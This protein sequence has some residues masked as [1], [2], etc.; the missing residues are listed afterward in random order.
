MLADRATGNLRPK[1]SVFRLY[2]GSVSEQGSDSHICG[3]RGCLGQGTLQLRAG[4]QHPPVFGIGCIISHLAGRAAKSFLPATRLHQDFGPGDEAGIFCRRSKS[5]YG[6]TV[7]IQ[8]RSREACFLAYTGPCRCQATGQ[9]MPRSGRW[10]NASRPAPLFGDAAIRRPIRTVFIVR[11]PP[12]P[13]VNSA[14]SSVG[15]LSI[16]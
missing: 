11:R 7:S 16:G 3:L 2:P 8:T 10:S 1:L 15:M 14:V 12:H 6:A 5:G 13:A 9:G 4:S